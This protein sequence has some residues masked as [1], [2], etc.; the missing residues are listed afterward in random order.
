MTHMGIEQSTKIKSQKFIDE[1]SEKEY[2]NFM[3]DEPDGM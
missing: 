3:Y 1:K 2:K